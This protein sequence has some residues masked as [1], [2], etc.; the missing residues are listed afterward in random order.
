[1]N[2][3]A[4]PEED[5]IHE[6]AVDV[7][8]WSSPIDLDIRPADAGGYDVALYLRPGDG[9]ADL[10][11]AFHRIASALEAHGYGMEGIADREVHEDGGWDL[12]IAV[13]G[14]F[15]YEAEDDADLLPGAIL[16]A[17]VSL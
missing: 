12:T 4:Y 7:M 6:I 16:A 3:P 15:V 5:R 9:I 13:C 10:D 1:M 2:A 8:A 14:R 17:P 11:E